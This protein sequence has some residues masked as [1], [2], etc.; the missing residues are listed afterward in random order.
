MKKLIFVT[1]ICIIFGGSVL[2]Q[3]LTP[4]CGLYAYKAEIVRVIDADTVV[5]DIDLGF[6]VVLR[7]EHLRLFGIDA[8]ER[9]T[10]AWK[11]GG[12]KLRERIIDQTLYICTQRMKTKEREAKGSF[13]RYLATIFIDGENINEWVLDEGLAQVRED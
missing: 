3:D 6:N 8:P 13:G 5:A 11:V 10:Q 2:A 9:G 12:D 1:P 7:D 4:D